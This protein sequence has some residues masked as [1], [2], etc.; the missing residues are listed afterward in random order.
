MWR[1]CVRGGGWVGGV[2]GT[3]R[4]EVGWRAR[5]RGGAG[6]GRLASTLA[7]L[8]GSPIHSPSFRSLGTGFSMYRVCIFLLLQ[9]GFVFSFA[10]SPSHLQL[11]LPRAFLQFRLF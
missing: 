8:G 9:L 4:A 5:A 1:V 7:L 2:G 6:R 10:Q 3:V 11:F